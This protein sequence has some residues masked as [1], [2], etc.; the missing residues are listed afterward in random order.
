[1]NK[2]ILPV[3]DSVSKVLVG[4][5]NEVQLAL[6]CLL[7][8]GHLLIEDIPGM[9]KTTLAQALAKVL[10]LEYNRVQFTSDLLP[11]DVIGSSIFN[12]KDSCFEFH[13]G[14]IFTQIL[15]ADEVNR[16]TPKTQSALLEAMAE[17]QVSVDGTTHVLQQP[18]FVI[19]TQNPERHGGTFPLPE[20]QLDRFTMRLSLGYPDK[21]A[22]RK[23]LLGE[24]GESQLVN[25]SSLLAKGEL[26]IMQR[27]V[28]GV[29]LSDSVLDYIQRLLGAS[30]R[31]PDI[32]TG[33]SPRAAQ[34][35]VSSAKAWAYISGRDYLIPEDVQT[36]FSS[37]SDHR[38]RDAAYLLSAT[39]ALSNAV[40]N[41][42]DVLD[43]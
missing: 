15:L 12:R 21:D 32:S 40:L 1:M 37:I 16:A 28:Q 6:A 41:S 4:K 39:G 13:P 3:I 24:A 23:I 11:G 17:G 25:M 9:G 30:R 36:V 10:G 42:V 34:A 35:L 27:Q 38:L 14:P 31:S 43:G 2:H 33:L 19:A 22:E 18:F 29:R 8:R 7:A 26:A 5:R 20:S